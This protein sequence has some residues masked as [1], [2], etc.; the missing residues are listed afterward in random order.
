MSNTTCS[1]CKDLLGNKHNTM[2]LQ[3]KQEHIKC[4]EH[5]DRGGLIYPSNS[6]SEVMQVAYN[7]F[8]KCV[9]SDL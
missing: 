9:A 2:D 3:V 6:L 7:V 8:N 1:K 4:T 5:L